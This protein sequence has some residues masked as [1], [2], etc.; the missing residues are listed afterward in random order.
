MTDCPMLSFL[1]V[2]LTAQ[3]PVQ[4]KTV[5]CHGRDIQTPYG[6]AYRTESNSLRIID[7]RFGPA[8]CHYGLS[9]LAG[10]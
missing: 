6:Q 9:L 2:V 7:P 1:T 8:G 4:A 3:K 5:T 10:W